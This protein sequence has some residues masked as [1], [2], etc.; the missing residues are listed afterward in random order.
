VKVIVDSGATSQIGLL[1]VNTASEK[2]ISANIGWDEAEMYASMNKTLLPDL[3]DLPAF[4]AGGSDLDSKREAMLSHLHD[5]MSEVI[6]TDYAIFPV[7]LKKETAGDDE[8]VYVEIMNDTF[9]IPVGELEKT[10]ALNEDIGDF[11]AKSDRILSR[12]HDGDIIP[13]D[14]PK[15]YGISPFLR[16]WK[17]LELVFSHYGFTLENNPFHEHEQL[18]KLVVLNNTMDA[19]LTGYL[20]YQGYGARHYGRRIP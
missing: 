5:V 10:S 19:V 18:R 12:V 1:A 20:Y 14:V 15:C 6:E 9:L 2:L 13:F 8:K 4:S 3:P 7:I 11:K 17:V 16:V